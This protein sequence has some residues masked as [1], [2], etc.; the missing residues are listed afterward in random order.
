MKYLTIDADD[1]GRKITSHYLNNSPSE[2]GKLSASLDKSTFD[3][4]SMLKG[5]GFEVI[6][7]AADG[8]AGYIKKDVDFLSVFDSVSELSPPE[9]TYSAG[10]GG[11]LRESYMAL[12]MAKSD[13]KSCLR[14]YSDLRD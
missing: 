11:T 5:L 8:I 13:G 7:C 2:L 3:V 12:M 14:F 6:F 4:S 10:V 1:I 9:F